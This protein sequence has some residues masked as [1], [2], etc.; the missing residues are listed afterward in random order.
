MDLTPVPAAGR[1][2]IERYA[3]GGFRVS[4]VS[5]VFVAH[6]VGLQNLVGPSEVSLDV[7]DVFPRNVLLDFGT[8]SSWWGEFNRGDLRGANR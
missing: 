2:I 1:Q 6:A 8:V 4:G 3:P 5:S 7:N